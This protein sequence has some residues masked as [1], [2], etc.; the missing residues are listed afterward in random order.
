MG[1]KVRILE[2]LMKPLLFPRKNYEVVFVA[3]HKMLGNSFYYSH[4]V[5]TFIGYL[6]QV[7]QKDP[8]GHSHTCNVAIGDHRKSMTSRDFKQ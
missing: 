4:W 2:M 1:S 8:K 7:N 5:K 6:I 3:Q